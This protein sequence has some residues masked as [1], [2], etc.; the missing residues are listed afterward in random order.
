MSI[1]SVIICSY[2]R[3]N[4]LPKAIDSVLSQSY[5]DFEL[6]IIDDASKDDTCSVVE[7]YI[8]KDA[9]I[10]YF[11]NDINLGISKSRNKGISLASGKYIA[12][13]DSDD[14]WIDKEKLNKQIKI[15]END[16]SIGLIGTAI[17]YVDEAGH[18][19][20]EDVYASTDNIIRNRILIKN[21]FAQSSVIF[22]KDAVES[23]G[24][25]NNELIVCEDF[26]LWL[27]IGHNFK[28]CNISDVTT[29][30]FINTKSISNSNK[31]LI[32]KTTDQII[33]KN[34]NN[35]PN[36]FLAKIKSLLRIIISHP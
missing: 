33:K 16:N 17:S 2:N 14:Y 34:R 3:S 12:M 6:L 9:R 26:D 21:Q 28:F 31:L 10:K 18:E 8:D 30:Y 25:Y 27:R 1:V 32:A 35:Y 22:K 20:R 4:L 13:L 15:L 11:K 23:V 24:A 19:I 7:K 29:A 36:Y 5:S